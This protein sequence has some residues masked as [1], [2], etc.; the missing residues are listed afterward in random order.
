MNV[1]KYDTFY[2]K[3]MILNSG[4]NGPIINVLHISSEVYFFFVGL[5]MQ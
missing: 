2:S 5:E 1:H 4:S 3:S